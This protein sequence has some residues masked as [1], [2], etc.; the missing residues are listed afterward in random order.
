MPPENLKILVLFLT[1]FTA[2]DLGMGMG[3]DMGIVTG[4]PMGMERKGRMATGII[5][6]NG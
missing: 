5:L 1:M 4:I 6:N 2:T 3:M